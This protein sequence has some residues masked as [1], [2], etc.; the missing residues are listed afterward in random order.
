MEYV[1]VESLF[2]LF[3]FT[4]WRTYYLL[5]ILC[6]LSLSD[7]TSKL[8]VNTIFVIADFECFMYNFWMCV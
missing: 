1:I 6:K 2:F 8:R 4:L 5:Q 3:S 7:V